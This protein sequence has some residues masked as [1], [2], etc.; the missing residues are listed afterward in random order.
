MKQNFKKGG[1]RRFFIIL[2]KIHEKFLFLLMFHSLI[3]FNCFLGIL[4]RNV[5]IMLRNHT[6]KKF[7]LNLC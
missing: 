5:S 4:F 2:C 7:F 3:V 6:R 1:F